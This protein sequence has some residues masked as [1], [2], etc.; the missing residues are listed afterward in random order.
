MSLFNL[1]SDQQNNLRRN[2]LFFYFVGNHQLGDRD[3]QV[4]GTQEANFVYIYV[5]ITELKISRGFNKFISVNF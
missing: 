2:K 4:C 5:T 3:R 1:N